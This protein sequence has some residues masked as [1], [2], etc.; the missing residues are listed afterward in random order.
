MAA[1]PP[2]PRKPA[3]ALRIVELET[4]NQFIELIQQGI[5]RA[6][7]ALWYRGCCDDNHGLIPSLYRHP[8]TTEASKLIDL[9]AK[10]LGRFKQRSVPYQ[11]RALT[12]SWEYLFFMQHFGIPTRLLDWT[13]NPYV[14]LYFALSG[15]ADGYDKGV[16]HYR[17]DAAVWVL[18]PVEW[19]RKALEDI[20][21]SGEV[22]SPPD[23]P[24]LSGYE[25]FQAP[26]MIRNHPVAIYGTHNS[27]RIVAQRGVFVIFGKGL[28]P[29][30]ETYQNLKFPDDT[31]LKIRI[32]RGR[33]HAIMKSLADIGVTDS[34][35]FPDLD[36]LA[37]EIRRYFGFYI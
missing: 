23:D 16:P 12:T 33:I 27:Y 3:T 1:K 6:G 22:L 29:M 2:S 25:P 13:E 14:G 31:L 21:W 24:P 32:P 35:V 34:V 17:S 11:T 19:N 9:E 36:G 5:T 28:L 7:R 30:E 4:I 20:G 26:T 37:K 8:T 10:I 15:H 18:D